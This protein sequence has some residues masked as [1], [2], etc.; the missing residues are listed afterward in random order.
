MKP[1]SGI[2]SKEVYF[3]VNDFCKIIEHR[4][5]EY[6]DTNN[7][8]RNYYTDNDIICALELV[9]SSILID[10]ALTEHENRKR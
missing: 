4:R 6:K 2:G 7:L 3:L 8:G 1:F 5:E 9:K 10:A